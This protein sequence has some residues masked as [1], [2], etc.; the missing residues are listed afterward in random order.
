[1]RLKKRK[2]VAL[3]AMLVGLSAFAGVASAAVPTDAE[4][5]LARQEAAVQGKNLQD[6]A[7]KLAHSTVQL[8][9]IELAPGSAVDEHRLKS[10]V[11]ALAR[12][13]VDI[14]E[15][16]RQLALYNDGSAL[17][18]TV[19]FRPD[20]AD[21]YRAVVSVKEGQKNH[22][23]LQGSNT[24]TEYTGGYR[25]TLSWLNGN[26]SGC[27]DT[28]AVAVTGSPG[29]WSDVKQAALAYRVPLP[30]I[31]DMLSLTASTAKTELEDIDKGLPFNLSD[32]GRSSRVGLHYEH[33]FKHSSRDTDILDFGADY[34]KSKSDGELRVAGITVPFAHYNVDHTDLMLA[35]RHRDQSAGHRFSCSVGARTNLT[36]DRQQFQAMTSTANRNYCLL[37]G[38]L[39]YLVRAQGDWLVNVR[40]IG[41]YAQQKLIGCEKFS[42]GGQDTVRGFDMNVLSAD[43]GAAGS[44]EIYTPQLAKGLR[45]LAFTDIGYLHDNADGTD[46]VTLS[47]AGAG[48]R[49]QQ[50]AFSASLDYAAV[51]HEPD[52]VKDTTHRRWNFWA[53][54]YF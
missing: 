45:L 37:T 27:G 28:L 21:A 23:G 32:E 35:F 7:A 26:L 46:N 36:G 22:F 9:G 4:K 20:G 30:H 10:L 18:I 6:T 5:A 15:L 49:Y 52:S 47:S 2:C 25:A 53:G 33:Y 40:G 41:Q 19:R 1:M 42:I 38:S 54:L 31:G 8:T 17:K 16:A 12:P 3:S 51:I 43:S 48:L 24:G 50:G 13:A 39:G 14:Q 11:P 34:H 44:L 29:H